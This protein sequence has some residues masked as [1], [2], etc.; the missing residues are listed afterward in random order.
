[1]L[2]DFVPRAKLPV[3]DLSM[4][5]QDLERLGYADSGLLDGLMNGVV[6]PGNPIIIP[7]RGITERQSTDASAATH[8]PVRLAPE[9]MRRNHARVSGPE[10]AAR[11]S[12]R[13]RSYHEA[14][15]RKLFPHSM[16]QEL[17]CIRLKCA[18]A[19]RIETDLSVTAI[20]ARSGFKTARYFNNVF[21][22]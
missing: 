19:L 4:M 5:R 1:M 12:G 21:R 17:A 16:R 7:P 20:A 15:F 3:V 14:G 6:V 22:K 18:K 10:D 11:V 2:A 9:F 8:E 13:P